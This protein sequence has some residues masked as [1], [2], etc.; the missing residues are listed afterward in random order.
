MTAESK[1][2]DAYSA[3]LRQCDGTVGGLCLAERFCLAHVTDEM[4]ASS[5]IMSHVIDGR[6][7]HRFPFPLLSIMLPCLS[8]EPQ[9]RFPG[10]DAMPI[11]E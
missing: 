5:A 4:A 11:F 9:P 6:V 7:C 1:R 10:F 8:D 3:K 2:A